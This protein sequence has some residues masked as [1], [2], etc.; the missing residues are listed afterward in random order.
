MPQLRIDS[1]R[2]PLGIALALTSTVCFGFMQIFVAMTGREIG[3]ME[4]TFFRNLIGMFVVGAILVRRGT[5]L[6]GERRYW[7]LLFARALF[8]FLGIL[9]L[10]YAA[11]NAAQADVTIIVQLSM[12]M[13]TA[14]SVAFLHERMTRMHIPAMILAFA[15]A[16]I[17][18][19]PSF[20][21]SAW[22]L[23]AAFGDAVCATITYILLSYFS[24][25]VDPLVV[26]LYF[27]VFSTALSIPL[28]WGSFVLPGAWDLFCLLMIGV[29]A[30]AA[31]VTLTYSYRMAPAGELS[32]YHQ[33][34]IPVNAALAWSLLGEV[35]GPRT[36]IGGALVLGA[37]FLLLWSK[38]QDARRQTA[39]C[40]H[41]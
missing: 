16:F 40:P 39:E 25:R 33:L 38:R 26:I 34:A 27:C 10:F 15:G 31:Q 7:P 36:L 23:L 6:L 18:A 9:S 22:P 5:P 12:F 32:V 37:S 28:M 41:A 14:A 35:P 2:R 24:G 11:R 4:Q 1:A 13:I 8:G 17:A 30:A 21:S 29:S 19:N 3:V 20:D